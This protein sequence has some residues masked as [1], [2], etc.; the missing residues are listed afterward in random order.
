MAGATLNSLKALVKNSAGLPG[1]KIIFMISDGF[2]L[3][4]RNSDSHQRLREVTAAAAAAGVIIYSIDA[5]G[6]AIGLPDASTEGPFDTSRRLS[7]ATGGDVSASQDVLS[8]LAAHTGRSPLP[9][10]NKPHTPG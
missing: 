10:A 5:R 1:R 4:N 9:Y 8:A 6:L 3:D 7:R 2:F